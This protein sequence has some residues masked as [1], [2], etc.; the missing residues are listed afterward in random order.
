MFEVLISWRLFSGNNW[1]Y[2]SFAYPTR[3]TMLL[4]RKEDL[5]KSLGLVFGGGGLW[6]GWVWVLLA[7]FFC[8]CVFLYSCE[9]LYL[10]CFTRFT[11]TSFSFKP[12]ASSL[13]L[14]GVIPSWTILVIFNLF[15]FGLGPIAACHSQWS[16]QI[17]E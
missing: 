15:Y 4:K 13:L 10:M 8:V 7:F 11:D 1:H 16:A 9:H 14:W 12:Q 17:M 3:K 5:T 2:Y 6:E